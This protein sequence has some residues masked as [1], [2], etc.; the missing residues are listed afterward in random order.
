MQRALLGTS[1]LGVGCNGAF[2]K[3]LNTTPCLSPTTWIITMWVRSLD[4]VAPKNKKV[5][6]SNNKR[7]KT[8][9]Q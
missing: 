8:I 4:Q 2:I 9:G 5:Q 6:G 3:P 1:F 7:K